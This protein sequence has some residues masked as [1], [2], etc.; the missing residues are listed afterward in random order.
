M[1]RAADSG[2]AGCW[3]DSSQPRNGI[4]FGGC[5][6]KGKYYEENNHKAKNKRNKHFNFIEGKRNR[7]TFH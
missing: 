4:S 1:D 3:F 7:K 5:A 2:S 6:T